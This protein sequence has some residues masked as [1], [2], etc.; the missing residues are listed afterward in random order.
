MADGVNLTS[1]NSKTIVTSTPVVSSIDMG[2]KVSEQVLPKIFAKIAYQKG[3]MVN[4]AYEVD[5]QNSLSVLIPRFERPA[6]KFESIR[7]GS[8]YNPYTPTADKLKLDYATL[9]VDLEYRSPIKIAEAQ[10]VQNVNGDKIISTMTDYVSRSVA[11][12]INY[13]TAEAFYSSIVDYEG[14]NFVLANA[15]K[16]VAIGEENPEDNVYASVPDAMAQLI[17]KIGN[18]DATKGDTSFNDYKMS[19]VISNTLYAKLMTT[20]GQFIIES[21]Y[22]QE[23]L[24]DGTLGRIT[25]GD[26]TSYKGRILGVDT[27]VLP[28]AFFPSVG[29]TNF[30]EKPTAGKVLGVMAVAEST[31]RV[32]VDRGVKI[33]D[34]V[35]FRGWVLQPLY[36]VGVT[37]LK[38][39]GAGLIVS[40]DFKSGN[41]QAVAG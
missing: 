17:C 40:S 18:A 8:D 33:T 10:I 29:N 32:F 4:N 28:D 30:T 41:E 31:E 16:I 37:C 7:G 27:F 24:I 35:E 21:S 38:P 36:R 6:G 26:L 34:A 39:W 25:L 15:K 3:Y 14:N 11:E 20:K 22:G 5:A 2:L 9:D 13:I 19:Q 23:I 1:H 12:Q